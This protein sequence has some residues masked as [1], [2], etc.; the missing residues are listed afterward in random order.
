MKKGQEAQAERSSLITE[1]PL[2][3]GQHWATALLVQ[4]HCSPVLWPPPRLPLNPPADTT[5]SED[6]RSLFKRVN[7][8]AELL[9]S[10]PKW[11]FLEVNTLWR[12]SLS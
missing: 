11:I 10:F 5:R 9:Q 4:S 7:Q 6:F 3:M 2:Q 1:F 8:V 12:K